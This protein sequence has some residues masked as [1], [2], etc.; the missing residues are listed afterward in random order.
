VARC[1]YHPDVE[2]EMSCAECGKPICPKEMVLTPVGYK[3]PEDARPKRSQYVLVKPGQLVRAIVVGLAVGVVGGLM[4]AAIGWGGFLLGIIWGSAT[5]EAVRRASGGHRGGTVGVV[6][7]ASLGV[8][9]LAGSALGFVGW[10]TFAVAVI[11]ALVQLAV[12]EL[13]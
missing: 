11:V 8:G 13:R 10:L 2:T 4:I 9:W 12:I 1:S 6:A 5:S 7:V 3:C